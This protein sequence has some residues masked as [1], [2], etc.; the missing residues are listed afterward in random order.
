MGEGR[1]RKGDGEGASLVRKACDGDIPAMGACDGPGKAQTQTCAR[2]G[3]ARIAA[4]KPVKD[5]GQV[6]PGYPN[7]GICD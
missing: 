7:S 3:A 2:F 5:V 4:K 6:G 1:L